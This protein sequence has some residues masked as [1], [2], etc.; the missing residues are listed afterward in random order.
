MRWTYVCPHCGA[1]LNPDETVILV[2]QHGDTRILLGFHPEPGT[3]RAYVPPGT[4]VVEGTTWDFSCPLCHASLATDV[5]PE[6]CALDM[7]TSGKRLR[8]YFSRM[9]GERATFVVSAEG[10]VERFGNH[11]ERHSLEMLEHV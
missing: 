11:A 8:V 4:D 3:Y 10:L 9:A 6:L 2:G 5:A 7:L 1:M